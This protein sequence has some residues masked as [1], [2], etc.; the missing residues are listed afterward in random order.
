MTDESG[1]SIVSSK[2]ERTMQRND[3]QEIHR[4]RQREFSKFLL[5]DDI[6]RYEKLKKMRNL[7]LQAGRPVKMYEKTLSEI[8]KKWPNEKWS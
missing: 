6:A 8:R 4:E 1:I 2:G 5:N 3:M 7:A